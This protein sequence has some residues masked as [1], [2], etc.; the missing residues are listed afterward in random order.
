[1]GME[2]L[3]ACRTIYL[4]TGTAATTF[5]PPPFV[6]ASTATGCISATGQR[7]PSPMMSPGAI[8]LTT[9]VFSSSVC[10]GPSTGA[11]F[12]AVLIG[13]RALLGIAVSIVITVWV[14]RTELTNYVQDYF[15]YGLLPVGAY[16][17]LFVASI[18]IYF[19]HAYAMEVL[20]GG[21]LVLAIVNIRNA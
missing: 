18:M 14:V 16:F 21:V 9:E 1:I 11:I 2:S 7:G 15:A 20:G 3:P 4:L 5:R 10:R 19:D 12:L 13:P 6:A 17:A 8:H